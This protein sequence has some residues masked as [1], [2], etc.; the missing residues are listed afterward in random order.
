M[1]LARI[2]D[3]PRET[4]LAGP[5]EAHPLNKK[6]G[7]RQFGYQSHVDKEH[8]KARILRSHDHIEGQDHRQSDPHGCAV[9]RRHKGF[10]FTDQG[11]PVEA[12]GKPAEPI[13]GIRPGIHTVDSR[14][15]GFG[16]VCTRT[17]T[18]SRTRHHDCAH[19]IVRIRSLEGMRLLFGH[20]RR[21]RVQLIGS[22]QGDQRHFI[23]NFVENLFVIHDFLPGS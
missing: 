19:V 16:H 11:H 3:S 13:G 14:L 7:T 5:S 1:G 17:E 8:A 18:A 15:E 21:P 6:M 10:G 20:T 23:A 2:V 4:H 12:S 22:V 9:H